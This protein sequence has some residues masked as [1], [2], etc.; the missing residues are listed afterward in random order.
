MLWLHGDGNCCDSGCLQHWSWILPLNQHQEDLSHVLQ[1]CCGAELCPTTWVGAACDQQTN[2]PC[3]FSSLLGVLTA[4]CISAR[5]LAGSTMSC[6]GQVRHAWS[7]QH[8]VPPWHPESTDGCFIHLPTL[9]WCSVNTALPQLAAL[10]PW[11]SCQHVNTEGPLPAG[12]VVS[13]FVTALLSLPH[14]PLFFLH[15]CSGSNCPDVLSA[16]TAPCCNGSAWPLAV[17]FRVNI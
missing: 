10:S 12:T 9:C 15:G 6:K 1:H 17:I 13:L 2:Q 14:Q 3:D 5:S 11:R 8:L 7:S 16:L 4:I